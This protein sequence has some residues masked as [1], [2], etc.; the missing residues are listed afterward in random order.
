[1]VPF[2]AFENAR[3]D[4]LHYTG[5]INGRTY[6]VPHSYRD[7][8]EGIQPMRFAHVVTPT[9]VAVNNPGLSPEE[10]SRIHAHIKNIHGGQDAV[11]LKEQRWF[12]DLGSNKGWGYIEAPTAS[13]AQKKILAQHGSRPIHISKATLKEGKDPYSR[14]GFHKGYQ[15]RATWKEPKHFMDPFQYHPIGYHGIK[16]ETGHKVEGST[17]ADVKNKID[18][19]HE[20]VDHKAFMAT[21]RRNESQN[22]HSENTLHLAKHY[23]TPEDVA[24]ATQHIKDNKKAGYNVNYQAN[25]ELHSKLW[26]KMHSLHEAKQPS[27][28]REAKLRGLKHYGNG[29]YG[30]ETYITHRAPKPNEQWGGLVALTQKKR[31]PVHEAK[32][33]DVPTYHMIKIAKRTL[34]MP[35]AMVGVMGGPNKDE[36]RAILKKHGYAV[37]PVKLK[38][39][40][41]VKEGYDAERWADDYNDLE[42]HADPKVKHLVG[43]SKKAYYGGDREAAHYHMKNAKLAASRSKTIAPFKHVK[44]D[45][46]HDDL[47]KVL[48]KHGYGWVQGRD[49]HYTHPAT[50]HYVKVSGK[51]WESK[52]GLH[53][54]HGAESLQTY[55]KN[56]H[57]EIKKSL[58]EGIHAPGTKVRVP[59]KGKMVS[60]KVVRYDDRDKHHGGSPFYVVDVG[61]Y[62]SAK[63]PAHHI[64]EDTHHIQGVS[65]TYDKDKQTWDQKHETFTVKARLRKTALDKALK[66]IQKLHPGHKEHEVKITHV[67]KEGVTG[68]TRMQLQKHFDTQTG[69]D[70]ERLN[71][72]EKAH[73]VSGIL[74]NHR[75]EIVSW[76]DHTPARL[77]ETTMLNFKEFIPENTDLTDFF[78]RGGKITV[79]KPHAAR[80]AQSKQKIKVPHRFMGALAGSKEKTLKEGD[81]KESKQPHHGQQYSWHREQFLKHAQGDPKKSLAH[82]HQMNLHWLQ[83]TPENRLK[84]AP[85]N[86]AVD[87]AMGQLDELHKS[88]LASYAEKA[89]TKLHA[90]SYGAGEGDAHA[91][92]ARNLGRAL[93][94]HVYQKGANYDYQKA[95]KRSAGLKAAIKKLAK[96]STQL[97]ELNKK[98]LS[99]YIQKAAGDL[100]YH[101]YAHGANATRAEKMRQTAGRNVGKHLA[102]D[103]FEKSGVGNER[104]ADKRVA[105]I[106]RAAKRLGEAVKD[107]V[108]ESFTR[109]HFRQVAD[110]ISKHPDEAKRRELAAHHSEIFSKSNPRFDHKRFYAAANAGDPLKK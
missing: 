32:K 26:E 3:K 39:S 13:E 59:H 75:K 16:H 40:E 97:D 29:E 109:K 87:Q 60:G 73:N 93:E 107:I 72:T 22:R 95:K 82:Y 8:H 18:Q 28:E 2:K 69:T 23:G 106:E 102:A 92:A 15:I 46:A 30:N 67:V 33:H 44:E 17:V 35:D 38:E 25:T 47:H 9:H 77:K 56:T 12:F 89:A 42:N 7:K 54:G 99:A 21:Y 105:G 27:H 48:V 4:E 6:V 43:L 20:S 58:T 31:V 10:V 64:K 94:T 83:L 1:M 103:F 63:V 86:E 55:I 88:T 100:G 108:R 76:R 68:P 85:L 91:T 79:A 98:T 104:K 96:E 81:S 80:G 74:L 65:Q 50:E 84:H 101:A 57:A 66:H 5:K 61:E 14:L 71:H 34:T 51:K 52:T 37:K 62:E 11:E 19:L 36:A 53:R 45:F 70:R 110:I 41:Q 24:T 49:A 90:H 78:K